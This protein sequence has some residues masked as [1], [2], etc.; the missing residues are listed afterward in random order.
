MLDAAAAEFPFVERDTALTLE[1]RIAI[2]SVFEF[3]TALR[4]LNKVD[5]PEVASFSG[6]I[7][8]R[9]THDVRRL[10]ACTPGLAVM[11]MRRLGL[12]NEG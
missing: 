5:R 1:A 8:R 10:A 2:V 12:W 9:A 11:P 3:E 6:D 4:Y 7:V